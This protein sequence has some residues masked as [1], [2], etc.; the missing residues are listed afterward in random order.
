MTPSLKIGPVTLANPVILAPMTGVTDLPYRN[1]AHNLGAG[2][3]ISEMVASRELVNGRKDVE[4]RARGADL[5]PFVIQLVGCDADLMA[6]AAKIAQSRGAR[7]IDINMGCPSREVTGKSSGSAL[8]RDLDHAQGLIE[9]VVGA[10]DVPVTL[11]MRLGWDNTSLN[12][13]DL[14]RR[15]QA[16]GVKL[17]TVHA[18]TRCQFFKG[19]ANWRSVADVKKAV[20]IPVI[21]NGDIKTAFDAQ[22]AIEES[23]ADGVM[24]GRGA[25]GAPWLPAS[26]ASVLTTGI[27]PGPP[28]RKAQRDIAVAHVEDMLVHYGTRVGLRN[29]RKHVGW[30]LE[31]CTRTD[32]AVTK[33][34]RRYLC[35]RDDPREVFAGLRHYYDNPGQAPAI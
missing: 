18:R 6:K 3:V 25:Y 10:V 11:K 5:N 15:A 31:Q 19:V 9:A 4:R 2:M 28:H 1:L 8:M 7:I 12:A 17:I 20:E 35:T 30:Y 27:D 23:G 29:A 24:I 26:I 34:W 21:V 16:C 33:A 14:A 13:P 22:K 32:K